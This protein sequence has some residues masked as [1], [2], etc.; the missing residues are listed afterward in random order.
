MAVSLVDDA[1]GLI[2]ARTIA[3][4]VNEA[5]EA[6]LHGV[7]APADIDLA[8]T[9]GVNYP[10]GPFAWLD[11]LGIGYVVSVLDNLGAAYGEDRYRVS[12][13]LRRRAA[14]QAQKRS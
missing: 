7:A 5:A 3:M 1:P 11:R 6:V 13:W 10:G 4:L 8:M 14:A 2:A 12:S 9:K